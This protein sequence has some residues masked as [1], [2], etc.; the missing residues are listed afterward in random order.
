[1]GC[2]IY[3]PTSSPTVQSSRYRAVVTE[4]CR[5]A[6]AAFGQASG[7]QNAQNH[8]DDQR[9]EIFQRLHTVICDRPGKTAGRPVGSRITHSPEMIPFRQMRRLATISLCFEESEFLKMATRK[10]LQCSTNKS[11]FKRIFPSTRPGRECTLPTVPPVH[12]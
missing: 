9:T 3:S 5:P 7:L 8:H 11:T 1:M 10:R 4:H 2:Y 6:K 12:L